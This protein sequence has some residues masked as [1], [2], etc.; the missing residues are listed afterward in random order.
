[1]AS[2]LLTIL[3]KQHFV[4]FTTAP[5]SPPLI[6]MLGR[7]CVFQASDISSLTFNI[8]IR[9]GGE[10]TSAR[11]CRTS[12]TACSLKTSFR[13]TSWLFHVCICL[14]VLVSAHQNESVAAMCGNS[15]EQRTCSCTAPLSKKCLV[16]Q[17]HEM[18]S[19]MLEPSHPHGAS[20]V[21][22]SLRFRMS[23]TVYRLN[24]YPSQV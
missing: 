20:Q 13:I 10:G 14:C 7:V 11:V 9:G 3:I 5:P 1:M 2:L 24:I 18:Q 6:S 15:T 22:S 23:A 12:H 17:L 8:E 16:V 4:I 21:G 19:W